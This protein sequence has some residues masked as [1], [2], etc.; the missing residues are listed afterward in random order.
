MSTCPVESPNTVSPSNIE[1]AGRIA[2]ARPSWATDA[3]LPTSDLVSDASVATTPIV[4]FRATGV[5][6]R[7]RSCQ[8]SAADGRESPALRC[9][10]SAPV[11]GSNTDP[12][13]FTT[14]TAP[15]VHAGGSGP[16]SPESPGG[17]PTVTLAV[18]TPPWSM[19]ARAPVPAPTDPHRDR[20]G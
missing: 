3:S 13:A 2:R 16:G 10:Q 19:P 18:P 17:S 7:S 5:E 14:A 9:S 4:V 12:L 8:A 15:T 1:W 6:G 20:V 11:E